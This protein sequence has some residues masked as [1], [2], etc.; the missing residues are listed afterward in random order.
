MAQDYVIGVS[1]TVQGNGW[2]AQM[3]CAIKA[4]ALASGQPVPLI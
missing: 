1:N 2:R 4:E 3:I